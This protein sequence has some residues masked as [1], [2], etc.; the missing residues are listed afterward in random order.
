[1]R[2]VQRAVRDLA[3]R[4]LPPCGPPVRM[5][6]RPVRGMGGE[7]R[8]PA[9]VLGPLRRDRLG[10]SDPR[11]TDADGGVHPVKITVPELSLVLLI[12]PSGS[13]KST[14]AASHF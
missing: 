4:P 5:A 13:G 6:S 14:F 11:L 8:V 3:G 2:G 1:E 10:R 12:G 7:G 9:R